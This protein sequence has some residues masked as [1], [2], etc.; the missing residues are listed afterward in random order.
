MHT[1]RSTMAVLAEVVR[2]GARDPVATLQLPTLQHPAAWPAAAQHTK[3][4][5]RRST[6][7]VYGV[8]SDTMIRTM[9]MQMPE[10]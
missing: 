3:L 8:I 2:P 10:I 1:R 7:Q 9:Q 5:A 4:V 6:W